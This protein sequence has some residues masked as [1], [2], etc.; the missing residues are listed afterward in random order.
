LKAQIHIFKQDSTFQNTKTAIDLGYFIDY[1]TRIYMGYQT[2]ESSDIQNKNNKTLSDYTNSYLTTNL[3]Y[4]KFDYTNSNF[5]EKSNLSLN[6]GIGKRATNDFGIVAGTSKQFY[7]SLHAMYNFYLNQKNCININYHNYFLKSD[8]YVISELFR[9]GGSNS[10][11]GFAENSLQANF[12][13]ALQ[14]EYRYIVSP[15]L[16]IHSIIDYG[17][18]QDDSTKNK[19]NLIGLGLGIGLNTKNGVLKLGFANGSFKNQEVKLYNTIIHI[20]YSIKF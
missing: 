11:R 9:F 19:G 16:Y 4:S 18:Y 1:N 6:I 15:S 13:T 5:P 8:T 2:T 10:M 14:T 3:E 20:N 17:Y 12:M 7:I